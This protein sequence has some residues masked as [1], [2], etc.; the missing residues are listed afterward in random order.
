MSE[1][2]E[3]LIAQRDALI[4]QLQGEWRFDADTQSI[5][6]VALKAVLYTSLASMPLSSLVFLF[7]LLLPPADRYSFILLMMAFVLSIILLADVALYAYVWAHGVWYR[8]LNPIVIQGDQ[9]TW[10][11]RD[12]FVRE[13]MDLARL[14]EVGRNEGQGADRYLYKLVHRLEQDSGDFVS[15][16][17]LCA[18]NEHNPPKFIPGMI[19]DGDRLVRTLEQIAEIN[20]QLIEVEE[21]ETA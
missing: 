13:K 10:D 16:V 11:K 19:E 12:G 18:R 8:K 3:E 15:K 1:T 6:R 4:E 5:N 9:L 7:A 20:T 21:P 2:R 14:N 17:I